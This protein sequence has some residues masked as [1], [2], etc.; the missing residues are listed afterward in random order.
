M[1]LLCV[2]NFMITG[3]DGFIEEVTRVFENELI[4][5]KIE[6]KEFRYCGFEIKFEDEYER[7]HFKFERS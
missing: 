4:I 1:I 6:D 3:S 7:I 2:H 5:S